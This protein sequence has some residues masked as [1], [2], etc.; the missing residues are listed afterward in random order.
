MKASL[1]RYPG[2]KAKLMG[3]LDPFLTE[4]VQGATELHDV[5]TGGMSVTLYMADKFPNLVLHVN[6]LDPRMASFYRVLT[7]PSETDDLC[8]MLRDTVPTI[9]WFK[10]VRSI[11]PENDVERAYHAMFFNRCCFSGILDG[12]PIGGWEQKSAYSVACR[13]NPKRVPVEV[14]RVSE[15]IGE[16]LVCHEEEAV[17]YIKSRPDARCYVDPPYWEM[18]G[19]IYSVKMQDS[20]HAF[21]AEALR[22]HARWVLSYDDHEAVRTLYSFARIE[23]IMAKYSVRG[24]DVPHKRTQELVIIPKL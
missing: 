3:S 24:K 6:D 23:P 14:K 21:L 19:Q 2:A 13:F 8:A 7:C 15:A 5:F 18:G 20:H 17:S 10:E 22:H 4:L 9:P 12:S 16:R 1:F 11:T